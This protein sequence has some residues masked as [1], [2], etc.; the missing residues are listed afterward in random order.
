MEKMKVKEARKAYLQANKTIKNDEVDGF[1]V[2]KNVNKIYPNGV[3]AVFD[4]SL[5][6][7]QNEF[8][9]LVGPSGCGKST[10]LRM[11]AGLEEISSGTLYID[12]VLSNH[13]PPK[14]RNIAMVFQ[15]YALYPQMSVYDNIAF[16]LKVKKLPSEEIKRR[17]YAAAEILGLGPYL[18]RK[19]RE[20]SGGQMQRVALG[21][22]IVRD[23]KLF[24]MDEPLS[25]LDAKLRVQM[26]SEIVKIHNQI[27]ATTV[28]V[29][30]D[31]T[32][33]MTMA[34]RIVVMNRG[35]IQQIGT[36]EEIYRNP[37]NLF[38]ATF[39][40]TPPMNIFKG[41]LRDKCIQ[42]GPQEIHLSEKEAAKYRDNALAKLEYATSLQSC[43]DYSLDEALLSEIALLLKKKGDPKKAVELC[44]KLALAKPMFKAQYEAIGKEIEEGAS[45]S[46]FLRLKAACLDAKKE[47]SAIEKAISGLC[48]KGLSGMEK[49]APLAIAATKKKGLF[50]LKRKQS[51]ATQGELEE[52]QVKKMIEGYEGLKDTPYVY[53]GLRPEDMELVDM[54]EEG[55]E[56][57]VVFSELLGSEY[58]IHINLFGAE[59]IA[60]AD[61]SRPYRIG[62]KIKIKIKEGKLRFYDPIDGAAIL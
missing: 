30:H 36:P 40:G 46:S 12:H 57:E 19:P 32:E 10:T 21:R 1:V 11:I 39:I 26:R 43:L 59:L 25:N 17:V 33:A 22:A 44:A 28:Y 61:N 41:V 56:S 7:E 53:C 35:Y 58:L 8:I 49:G 45:S 37:A 52:E 9:V 42:C 13:L 20:L 50:G 24:L 62:D 16:G 15:S 23:A 60:K 47:L 48:L 5:S 51:S 27:R 18:D 55:Y 54:G 14:D 3:Q 34:S 6:I 31:Q 29:T 4:F 38:V 2:L